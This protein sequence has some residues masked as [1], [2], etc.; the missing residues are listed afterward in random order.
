MLRLDGSECSA[1]RGQRHW[2]RPDELGI[3][4][5]KTRSVAFGVDYDFSFGV[6]MSHHEI[7]GAGLPAPVDRRCVWTS[8]P[9]PEIRGWIFRGHTRL[10]TRWDQK[11]VSSMTLIVQTSLVRTLP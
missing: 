2:D 3:A 8:T 11:V 1:N 7:G 9:P 4:G 5:P 6:W 10:H